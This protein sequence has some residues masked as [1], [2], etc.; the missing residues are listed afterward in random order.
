MKKI[1]KKYLEKVTE[2]RTFLRLFFLIFMFTFFYYFKDLFHW[3]I[4]RKYPCSY[5][6][7]DEECHFYHRNA[8]TI[9]IVISSFLTILMWLC[10]LNNQRQK[11]MTEV[12]DLF[13]L[14]SLQP[15]CRTV[16]RLPWQ[17]RV[18]SYQLSRSYVLNSSIVPIFLA[19]TFTWRA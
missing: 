1:I 10:M 4:E 13:H 9:S 17:C 8:K 5:G 12:G 6:T 11:S 18:G 16:T 3:V 15:S 14:A 2:P 7:P 19:S